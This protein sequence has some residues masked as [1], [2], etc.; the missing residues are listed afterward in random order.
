VVVVVGAGAVVG[1]VV[2]GAAVVGAT[3]VLGVVVVVGLCR[4][5]ATT[6]PLPRTSSPDGDAVEQPTT[7]S[8]TQVNAKNHLNRDCDIGNR[9]LGDGLPSGVRHERCR[10]SVGRP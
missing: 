1:G 3:V 6:P 7:V 9:P 5:S 8:M 4:E 10:V 2:V